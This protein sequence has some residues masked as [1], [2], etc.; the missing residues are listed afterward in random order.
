MRSSRGWR[1]T[2]SAPP[3][4]RSGIA[5]TRWSA[6]AWQQRT[7]RRRDR[8]RALE[9]IFGVPVWA[10]WTIAAA[11]LAFGEVFTPGL[12]FLG[13]LAVAALVAALVATLTTG[14]VGALLAFT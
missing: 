11:L 2:A 6:Q 9:L 1:Q 10:L 12:F 8:A 5:H 13:P 3:N 4:C 7:D 14:A